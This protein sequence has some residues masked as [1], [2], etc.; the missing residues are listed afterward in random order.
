MGNLHWG[1]QRLRS[2][3]SCSSHHRRD[4][5]PLTQFHVV[6]SVTDHCSVI[7][8]FSNFLEAFS[9]HQGI[10]WQLQDGLCQFLKNLGVNP[11]PS[12][13]L[14]VVTFSTLFSPSYLCIFP[15]V[16]FLPFVTSKHWNNKAL[17]IPWLAPVYSC[18]PK[19]W[20]HFVLFVQAL[21][22]SKPGE[23]F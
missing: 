6:K 23:S 5:V 19:N 12:D 4:W 20:P 14:E 17:N 18:C 3:N 2:C 11:V 8:W 10:W 9:S 22:R 21:L 15:L 13:N 7:W 1:S 16:F